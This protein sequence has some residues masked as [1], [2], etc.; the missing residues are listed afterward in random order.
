MEQNPGKNW[1]AIVLAVFCALVS[2]AFLAGGAF[3][4]AGGIADWKVT[5][6]ISLSLLPACLTISALLL[7]ITLIGR[8]GWF[9]LR[10]IKNRPSEPAQV[11]SFP[12]WVGIL[13]FIGWVLAILLATFLIEQPILQWFSLPF[14]LLAIGLPIYGLIRL[15]LG[16]LNPGSKLRAWGTLASGMTVAPIIAV[17]GEGFVLI[18]LV[19]FIGILIG[20]DPQRLEEIRTMAGQLK[21]F[22][23][24]EEAIALLAPFITNPLVLIG[25]L[26]FLSI[27]TPLI[28]ETAKSLPVWMAWSRLESPAQGFA[29]GALS[30][31]GFGLME[32]LLISTTPGTTWGATLAVRAASSAMH[33][34]TSG[35]VGW[36][37][38]IAATQKR[39]LPV[40]GRYLLGVSI[41]GIWNACVMIMVY[42]SALT[43]L[44]GATSNIAASVIA[45]SALC[46]LSLLILAAPVFL[47][48]LN[49]QFKKSVIT[50]P[51]PENIEPASPENMVI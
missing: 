10:R 40:L 39:A 46:L 33:I 9:A 21:N 3:A 31:A 5:H 38:G 49:R 50:P 20:F 6:D 30:G 12:V 44:S 17:I 36:G 48:A 45:V 14:Y 2:L 8:A 43:V 51:D 16:G 13:L 19:V 28:E 23:T 35:I 26:F 27:V 24:Q 22:S 7:A 1:Q 42:A 34:I 29:L 47:W 18:I 4:L 25:G 41:H 32:G 15:G 37:I 11:K